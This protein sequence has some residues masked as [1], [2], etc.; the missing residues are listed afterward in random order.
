MF[1][2]FDKPHTTAIQ[3]YKDK[4]AYM[5]QYYQEVT[6]EELYKDIFPPETLEV[7]G[8]QTVR[9][10]NPIFSYKEAVDGKTYFR[11]EVVFQNTFDGA[12]EKTAKN[13]M[14]L[15]SM[16]SYSGRNK[17]AK[18]AYKCHGFIIDLDGV[19]LW[20]LESF[21]GWVEHL[22]KI[23]CPTYV[24]N[25]GHGLHIY[26]VFENPVPLYPAVAQHL[27]NLKHGL[28]EW[29]WNRETSSYKPKDRQF[30]GIYQ[31]FRMVGSQSKLGQGRAK[32]KYLVKGWKTG[33]RVTIEYLNKF[34]EDKYK[35]PENPDYSSWEW[36]DDD[37]RHHTLEEAQ[38]LW[39]KWYEHRIVK[40]EPAGQ[41]VCNKGLYNWWY[42]KIQ[43]PG[44]AKDGNRYYCISMLYV[45]AIKCNIAK[46]IVDADAHDLIEP[47]NE[48]TS[49]ENNDFTAA[50][51][52]AASKF[53]NTMYA[54]M[55]KREVTRKTGIIIN[56]SRRNG[57]TQEEHLRRAGLIRTLSPYDNVGA[58]KKENIVKEWRKNNPGGKKIDCEKETGLS[59]HT[60]LK[61]W[62]D[63]S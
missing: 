27:Q 4:C 18:N 6:A 14:A 8:D 34:V 63:M 3:N 10:S 48:L 40:G 21:W 49:H 13:Q 5:S 7:K 57:R 29:V 12:L 20:E 47:F 53:Y 26:Y 22:E 59:R 15:C 19:G 42:H 33:K 50:D 23:P 45:Y 54:K 51:V 39:P 60:V 9:A 31:S 32:N 38:K 55:S 25:S 37:E 46:E 35:C 58:P 61:W 17:T 28:T 11:N 56:S 44:A 62:D 24:V 52:E 36:A 2:L 41:W 30:Q 1:S 16:C 43:E